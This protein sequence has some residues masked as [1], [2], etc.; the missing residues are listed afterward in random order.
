[1]LFRTFDNKLIEVKREH[2]T[3]DKE[4]FSFIYSLKFNK[5]FLQKNNNTFEK[6]ISTIL[7][8]DK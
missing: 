8:E 5:N 1:M 4:Y 6:I 2:F 7:Y 3:N